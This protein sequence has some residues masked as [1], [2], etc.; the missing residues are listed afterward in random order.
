MRTFDEKTVKSVELTMSDKEGK[1]AEDVTIEINDADPTEQDLKMMEEVQEQAMDCDDGLYA[2]GHENEESVSYAGSSMQMYLKEIGR[3]PLL[4]AEEEAELGKIISEGGEAATK[5]RNDLIQ[6]N[7]R[8]VV[9]C[10]KK[11]LGRGL[12]LADLN[13]MGIEGLIKAAGKYDYSLGFR[14]STYALWWIN[15]AIYRG[16]ANEAGLVKIPVHLNETVYK[17]RKARK[18]L[19]QANGREATVEEI[20]EFLD[21]PQKT[22]MTAIQATYNIVSL[23]KMV[24]EDGDATLE[25]FLPDENAEDPCDAAMNTGLKEAV[26][27][28]LGKLFPKEALVLSLR[29]G[30]G[31]GA[32]M[33]LEEVANHPEFG[34]TRERIRQIES[35]AIRRIR[36]TPALMKLLRDFAA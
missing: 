36:C 22:V 32:P 15:Q 17:V 1:T 27:K 35:K 30:I 12:E 26:H 21:M 6:A 11:Y 31:T 13:A 28:V 25:Y 9:F 3:I 23:D 29:Y 14:F 20:S 4:S 24:G 19:E 2:D 18:S 8:L 10:A 5:A 33:T 7:L 34:V 16:I